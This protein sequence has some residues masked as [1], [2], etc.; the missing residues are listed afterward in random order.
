MSRGRADSIPSLR[1]LL[2]LELPGV[3]GVQSLPTAERCGVGPDHAADGG[4]AEQVIEHV[5]ADVPPG[6]PHGDE[7]TIDGGPQCQ[8]CAA[9]DGVEPPPNIEAT[10]V[11]F[12]QVG[13]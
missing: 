13:R 3:L 1:V 10:P 6:S 8:A 12:E 11:V 7:T 9:L 2:R 4:A 5:E